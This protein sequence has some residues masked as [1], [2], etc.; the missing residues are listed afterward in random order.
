MKKT[1]PTYEKD[2]LKRLSHEFNEVKEAMPVDEVRNA[3]AMG[4]EYGLQ[5][6]V[7]F[8]R[9]SGG[10]QVDHP[11]MGTTIAVVALDGT[12]S[13]GAA[14]V[15]GEDFTSGKDSISVGRAIALLRAFGDGV[16][17]FLLGKE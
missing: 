12:I 4:I 8:L 5:A 15:S 1:V 14:I 10:I 9:G 13:T 16:P 2:A 3:C 11:T 6:A 7:R 17:N